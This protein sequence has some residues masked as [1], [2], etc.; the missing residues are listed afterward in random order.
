METD[1]D[2]REHSIYDRSSFD[3]FAVHP[4]PEALGLPVTEHP[5]FVLN[6]QILIHSI[7]RL[8]S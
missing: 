4:K 5:S 8:A 3:L 1:Y 2:D 7:T 6:N